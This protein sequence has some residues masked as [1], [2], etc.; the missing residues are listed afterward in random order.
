VAV[1]LTQRI[2]KPPELGTSCSDPAVAEKLLNESW[3]QLRVHLETM[4]QSG[5]GLIGVTATP[6]NTGEI[7]FGLVEIQVRLPWATQKA[8]KPCQ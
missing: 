7:D 5:T 4:V 6:H 8:M 3:G 2:E 1:T